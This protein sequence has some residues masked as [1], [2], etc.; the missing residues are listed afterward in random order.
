MHK[1]HERICKWCKKPFII[2]A[3]RKN[4]PVKYCSDQC[5]KNAKKEQDLMAQRRYQLRYK[6][7][8]KD[9]D[10]NGRLGEVRLGPK[11]SPDFDEEQ[12]LIKKELK[13]CKL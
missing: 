10:P 11:P 3:T 7:M 2:P 5:R 12:R 4:N 6:W 1:N 8:L 9:A 13:R